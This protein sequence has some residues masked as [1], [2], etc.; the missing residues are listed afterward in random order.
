MTIGGALKT[1]T[2]SILDDDYSKINK[3]F[4]CWFKSNM[5]NTK[6][7]TILKHLQVELEYNKN[8]ERLSI[9]THNIIQLKFD[10]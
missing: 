6:I 8:F 3:R 1:N 10:N 7:T 4:K 2:M 9:I 5:Q